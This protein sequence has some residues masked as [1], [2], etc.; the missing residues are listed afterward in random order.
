MP[1]YKVLSGKYH[2]A[3]EGGRTVYRPGDIIEA[4][5]GELDS[6]SNRFERLNP[7]P[8]KTPK[9]EKG[10]VVVHRGG[11]KYNVINEKTGQPINSVLLTKDD[12][13]RL[14]D[15]GLDTPEDMAE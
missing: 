4:F 10:L 15:E 3:E 11:G 2:R 9:P 8:K 5:E 14:V 13:G 1:R 12:A 6:F 7:P